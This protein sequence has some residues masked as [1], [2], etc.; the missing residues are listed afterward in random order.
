MAM[1]WH[2]AS[3]GGLLRRLLNFRSPHIGS[4][5]SLS[6][7]VTNQHRSPANPP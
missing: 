7:L 4:S 5:L 6:V 3:C 2:G 1:C